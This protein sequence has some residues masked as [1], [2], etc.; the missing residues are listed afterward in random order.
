MGAGASANIPEGKDKFTKEEVAEILGDDFDEELFLQE[1]AIDK[2]VTAAQLKEMIEEFEDGVGEGAEVPK[3]EQSGKSRGRRPTVMSA[4]VTVAADWK[5]PVYEKSDEQASAIRKDIE[6]GKV[7]MLFSSVNAKEMDVLV[8]AFQSK[9]VANGTDIIKQ[10]DLVAEE[11]YV[12]ADGT[13]EIFVGDK[14]VLDV[15]KGGCFGELA[16][17]YDAPR[18]ATVKATSDSKVWSLDRATFK[19]ILCKSSQDQTKEYIAFL[20]K[21]ESLKDLKEGDLSKLADCAVP[22]EYP[23]D[24]VIIEQGAIGDI[25]YF[26]QEGEVKCTRKGEDGKEEEVFQNDEKK[27]RLKEGDYFG[28]IALL[29]NDTRQA[30]VTAVTATKCL[31]LQRKVFDRVLGS[32]DSLK[33]NMDLTLSPRAAEAKKDEPA[34][35]ATQGTLDEA[36]AA[37]AEGADEKKE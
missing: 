20:Q 10:G 1:C 15:A 29:T 33:A 25:F 21:V 28:E 7:A 27:E 2:T 22:R 8:A 31:T 4:P 35:E 32:L 30:T 9:D 11:F 37:A 5:P 34:P 17:L 16:L 18:A 26:V 12:V 14:K 13:F 23:A 36:S 3:V 24:A 6:A 19:T